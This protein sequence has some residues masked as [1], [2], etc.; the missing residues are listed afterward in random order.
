MAAYLRKN[1]SFANLAVDIDAAATQIHVSG[2]T[3]PTTPGNMVLVVWDMEA[4]ENPADDPNT[5]IMVGSYN[6]PN[7]YDVVRAQE[8]TV[9]VP[10]AKNSQIAMHISAGLTASD[11]FYVGNHYVNEASIGIGKLLSFDGIELTYVNPGGSG[12][13][14]KSVYDADDDGK[15]DLDA[16]GTGIDSSGVLDGQIL[17]GKNDHTFALGNIAASSSKLVVVNSGHLISLDVDESKINHNNL[18]NYE[19]DEHVDHTSVTFSA[20]VGIQGGGDLSSDRTFSI[21]KRFLA[22]RG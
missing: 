9:A 3:L 7:V 19:I 4:Y 13:M 1:F 17:I 10:H 16:G 20:G 14:L 22:V 12:D 15:I 18:L 6:A 5:E 11:M 8:S 2:S 21:S